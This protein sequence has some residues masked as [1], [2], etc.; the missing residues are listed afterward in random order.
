MNR[1]TKHYLRIFAKHLSAKRLS[2]IICKEFLQLNNKKTKKKAQFRKWTKIRQF[3]REDIK[4]S[5]NLMKKNQ[6][7]YI[8]ENVY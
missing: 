3:I 1:Q 2:S 5:N 8:S 6:Y 4:V 7:H